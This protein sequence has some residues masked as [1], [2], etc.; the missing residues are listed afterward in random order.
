MDHRRAAFE[1]LVRDCIRYKTGGLTPP[2]ARKGF[3]RVH[4]AS[5]CFLT[6]ESVSSPATPAEVRFETTWDGVVPV[7]EAGFAVSTHPCSAVQ[8]RTSVLRNEDEPVFS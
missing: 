2:A 1:K 6:R 4:R 7:A 5:S 3:A 8:G